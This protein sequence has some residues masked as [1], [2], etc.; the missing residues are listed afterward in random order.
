[1]RAELDEDD[2]EGIEQMLAAR[3]KKPAT[4][5]FV[6]S[7]TI[8]SKMHDS[9]KFSVNYHVLNKRIKAYKFPVL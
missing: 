8:A 3:I 5:P 4:S 6:F 2:M 1:M 9:T 7:V